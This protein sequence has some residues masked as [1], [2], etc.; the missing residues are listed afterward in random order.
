MRTYTHKQLLRAIELARQKY[1]RTT[2]NTVYTRPLY[3]NKKII[4]HILKMK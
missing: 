2:T 1:I 4:D 3:N